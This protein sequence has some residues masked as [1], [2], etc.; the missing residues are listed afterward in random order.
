MFFVEGTGGRIGDGMSNVGVL[1]R[2]LLIR[3]CGFVCEIKG[4]KEKKKW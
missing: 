1:E 4:G 3:W 2:L